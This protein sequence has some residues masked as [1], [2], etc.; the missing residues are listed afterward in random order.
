MVG[1]IRYND[2]PD[3]AIRLERANLGLEAINDYF[4]TTDVLG[5]FL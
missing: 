1:H 4:D 3:R 5:A 2:V